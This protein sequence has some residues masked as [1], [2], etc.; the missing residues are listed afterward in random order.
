MTIA[1]L[2]LQQTAALLM[3]PASVQDSFR[4]LSSKKSTASGSSGRTCV[5]S[6]DDFKLHKSAQEMVN[7]DL[8]HPE[9]PPSPVS[10]HSDS[11]SLAGS[12][13]SSRDEIRHANRHHPYSRRHRPPPLELRFTMKSIGR[14]HHTDIAL[15]DVIEVIDYF[16]I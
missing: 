11:E 8:P 13:R 5:G 2:L 12:F 14:N 7:S 9:A 6:V 3:I 10:R 15:T 16:G 1:K 4:S